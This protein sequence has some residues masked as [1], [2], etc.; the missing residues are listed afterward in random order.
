MADQQP[1]LFGDFP[2]R[3]LDDWERLAEPALKGK[4]LASLVSKDADGIEIPALSTRQSWPT[5]SDPAGVPGFFP[6]V[7][8][9]R[10][11]GTNRGWDIR[12]SYEDP[13]VDRLVAAIREDLAGGVT[14][15]SLA[16]PLRDVATATKILEALPEHAP[17]VLDAHDVL[18]SAAVLIAAS[19]A[20]DRPLVGNLGL[21]PLAALAVRGELVVDVDTAFRLV[22]DIAHHVKGRSGLRTVLVHGEAY[23][24]GGATDAQQLAYAI[25]CGLSY[26][27]AF[28][29]SGFS[30][31]DAN[32]QIAFRFAAGA[33]VLRTIAK[34]RAARQIWSRIMGAC[35]ARDDA[36]R[37]TIE[38]TT[39][40]RALS[41]HD[42]WVNVLR[43]TTAAFGAI[44]GGA[45]AIVVRTHV[46]A[47]GVP[48]DDARRL[49]KNVQIIL[50]EEAHVGQVIDPAGGAWAIERLTDDLARTA[51]KRLQEIEGK[52][53][54]ERAIEVGF[55]ARAVEEAYF[56]RR[57]A[58]ATRRQAITGVSDY[59]WLDEPAP[60]VLTSSTAPVEATREVELSLTA[61]KGRIAANAVALARLGANTADLHA[62]LL[63]HEGRAKTTPMSA[64]RD[65]GP[66]EA[67]RA[68]AKAFEPKILLASFGT[69]AEH[70][71]RTAFARSF[72]EAGG[73]RAIERTFEDPEAVAKAVEET[74][75]ELAVLCS[76]DAVYER[77]AEDYARALK[78]AGI[79][80]LYLAGRPGELSHRY[81]R[82]GVDAYIHLGVDAVTLLE[83]AQKIARG[84]DR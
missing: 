12:Q 52:G 83:S 74:G 54:M 60:A 77:D 80:F 62:A 18:E 37:T 5:H 73:I 63:V 41:R 20:A 11:A 15:I 65:A 70:T 22:T 51:W 27:R 6:Y 47:V 28:I 36:R 50:R 48:D 56:D 57:N 61:P 75:A 23:D 44:A 69:M 81:V 17:I 3:H 58:I 38:A 7:R 13:D 43:A 30:L 16:A 64:R 84:E 67:L 34:L 42:V 55:V 45:D 8:G 40:R 79:R 25:G 76:S 10:A 39:S 24:D 32:R 53:G 14:S 4:K 2:R 19:E 33:D 71:P 82:G 31:E 46:D 29:A 35:G 1:D 21:D 68:R 49:A 26:L 9:T 59:P 78:R 66:F 72:F